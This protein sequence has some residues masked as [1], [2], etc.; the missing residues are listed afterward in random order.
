MF[1]ADLHLPGMLEGRIKRSPHAH[2]RIVSHRHLEGAARCRACMAVVTSRGLPGD[3]VRGSHWSGD[4]F[5]Q[6]TAT[7]RATCMARGKVLYDGHA[8][9]A[10]AATSA[11]IAEEALD[12]IEVDYEVLPHVIDVEAAMAPDAPLLHDDLFTAGLDAAADRAVQHR[13]ADHV[14]QRRRRSRASPRPRWW[15]RAATPPRPCTRAIS[16]RTPAWPPGAPMAS[17]R[18]SA[19]ARAHFMVRAYSAKL[20]GLDIANIRG[21]PGRDRRRLRRQDDDLPGAGGA[22]AVAQGR[23]AGALVMSRE[24]VFRASGPTSGGVVE[25]KLGA[26]RD[27]TITA[28]A[29]WC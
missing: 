27:G 6:S 25:V 12:L 20:L 2:A 7:S 21:D 11:A 15:W 4:G 10:V 5:D 26:K 9:A 13:Q 19:P 28:A 24:E 17:A 1:G 3:P 8:V 23:P 29:A 18:S 14:R 16:S 22:G